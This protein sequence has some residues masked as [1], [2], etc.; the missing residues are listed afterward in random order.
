MDKQA[1]F[2]R[3]E[4]LNFD[5]AAA[6]RLEAEVTKETGIVKQLTETVEEMSSSLA[7]HSPCSCST[8]PITSCS[9]KTET[10]RSRNRGVGDANGL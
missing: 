6:E 7:G 4:A 10:R 8:H 2:C 5:K 9:C 3:L 1:T